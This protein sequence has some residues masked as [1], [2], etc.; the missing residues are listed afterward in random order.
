MKAL[1]LLVK[2][3]APK[4]HSIK[5][6]REFVGDDLGL[7]ESLWERAY[8]LTQYYYVAH[9]PDIVEGVPDEAISSERASISVEVAEKIVQAVERRVQDVQAEKA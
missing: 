5:R 3:D 9:Y 8:E 2:K 4:T 1:A 7:P 6:L